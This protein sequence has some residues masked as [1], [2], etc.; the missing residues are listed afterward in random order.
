MREV[1]NQEQEAMKTQLHEDKEIL[2]TQFV[3]E[4]Q[5]F[6]AGMARIADQHKSKQTVVAAAHSTHHPY[7]RRL[8]FEQ[9]RSMHARNT[10]E[11]HTLCEVSSQSNPGVATAASIHAHTTEES[12]TLC[13]VSSQSNPGVATAASIHAHTTEESHTLCEVSSQSNPG[14]ATAAAAASIHAHT[15]E[16]SHTLCEVSSQSNPGVATAAAAASIHAHT[17]EESHTLCEESSES[18][19]TPSPQSTPSPSPPQESTD[20]TKRIHRSHHKNPRFLSKESTDRPKTIHGSYR[21]NPPILPQKSMQPSSFSEHKINKE[22]NQFR[23]PMKNPNDDY[24]MPISINTSNEEHNRFKQAMQ[25]PHRFKQPMKNPNDDYKMPISINTSN[26]EHNR[27][28]QAMQNP[29]RFKQP[30]KNP[31]DDYKMPISINKSNEEHNRFRQ[32][33]KNTIDSDKSQHMAGANLLNCYPSQDTDGTSKVY[34]GRITTWQEYAGYGH[35]VGQH[36]ASPIMFRY[37]ALYPTFEIA[38]KNE[39][40]QHINSFKLPTICL[41]EEITFSMGITHKFSQQYGYEIES[42]E[43]IKVMPSNMKKHWPVELCCND[44]GANMKKWKEQSVKF[45][46]KYNQPCPE[47]NAEDNYSGQCSWY[48]CKFHHFCR[49]CYEK[50]PVACCQS[51]P[52]KEVEQYPM[53]EQKCYKSCRNSMWLMWDSTVDSNHEED[54]YS[55]GGYHS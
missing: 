48:Q 9:P 52:A 20:P 15:T 18:T 1:I 44:C 7:C 13:E 46:E 16:E 54:S 45:A 50:H 29:H 3:I 2:E 55:D 17:T 23:K 27:F 37:T 11:S 51:I 33:M 25:N 35:I 39:D 31:N 21:K 22:A 12:H 49:K 5:T 26:E 40:C 53:S 32:P 47:Y 41:E 43:A 42:Y 10:E 14:V 4:N 34:H 24:K 38:T 8:P 28:K 30:M 36:N 6:A 19:Q